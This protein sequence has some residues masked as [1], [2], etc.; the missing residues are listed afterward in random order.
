MTHVLDKF[1][2]IQ[3][4]S[5]IVQQPQNS[6]RG[7]PY[8]KW[9][10]LHRPEEFCLFLF[11]TNYKDEHLSLESHLEIKVRSGLQQHS[12]FHHFFQRALTSSG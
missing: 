7:E 1:L 12:P 3:I 2:Y 6:W 4:A 9:Y 5:S 10:Y 11:F 8:T